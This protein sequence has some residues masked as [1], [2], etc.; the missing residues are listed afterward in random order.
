MHFQFLNW[1][2]EIENDLKIQG[3][4]TEYF[5]PDQ[6]IEESTLPN[7]AKTVDHHTEPCFVRVSVWRSRQ[8]EF[9][10]L[11]VQTGE[12]LLWEYIDDIGETPS[13]Q[14]ILSGY[15]RLLKDGKSQR[16]ER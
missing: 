5:V 14:D 7:V 16:V 9:E 1:V 2:K 4:L 6:N 15:F 12:S 3:I 13:F 11:D 10:V 8:M